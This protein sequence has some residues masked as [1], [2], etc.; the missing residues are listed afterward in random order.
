M[1]TDRVNDPGHIDPLVSQGPR[2]TAGPDPTPKKL[3][4]TPLAAAEGLESA[5]DFDCNNEPQPDPTTHLRDYHYVSQ[6]ATD[7]VGISIY[8]AGNPGDPDGNSVSVTMTDILGNVV[9]TE[10][11]TRAAVGQ[12]QI[13]FTSEQTDTPGYFT[14]TWNFTIS[15]QAQET[16]TYIQVGA[17]NPAYDALPAP[18]KSIV[19][20]TWVRFSDVFDSPQGG[21]HLQVYFQTNMSRGRL[22]QLLGVAVGFLNTMA[23]PYTSFSVDG[24][25]LFPYQQWGP[26]L[27]QTLYI[28]TLKHLMRSYT[29]QPQP[30]GLSV[31][32]MDRRD[33]VDRWQAILDMEMPFFKGQLDV[34]KISMMGLGRPR[35]LVSGGVFGTYGPTRLPGSAAAR[36]HMWGRYY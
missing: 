24:P 20:T 4:E 2:R 17:T 5:D 27:E 1:A 11:A 6:F 23:Q 3:G 32:R 21:P 15:S 9:F 28:E 36:P 34:F 13:T 35:V 33:Y 14:L 19:E 18:M 12:Y 7:T 8:I 26:L 30:Q 29:E 31:A 25:P 10:A 16:Q 22:A